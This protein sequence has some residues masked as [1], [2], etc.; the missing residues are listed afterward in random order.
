MR[1]SAERA[2]ES[3]RHDAE[4]EATKGPRL[5]GR[6]KPSTPSG[7][8]SR[9]V[10]A[11]QH[12]PGFAFG[13]DST[14]LRL[15][16]VPGL[17]RRVDHRVRLWGVNRVLVGEGPRIALRRGHG[18]PLWKVGFR[19]LRASGPWGLHHLSIC[20][21]PLHPLHIPYGSSSTLA[22]WRKLHSRRR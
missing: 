5:R 6:L 18:E 1:F 21:E 11:E 4:H 3:L 7:A 10:A 14:A 15:P 8:A 16:K 22:L 20:H 9:A 13:S 17:R 12:A 2:F 19:Q